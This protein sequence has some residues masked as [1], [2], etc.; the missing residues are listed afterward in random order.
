MRALLTKIVAG[1]MIAGSAL[2]VSA[3]GETTV[4][5]NNTTEVVPAENVATTDEMVSSMDAANGTETNMVDGNM[6]EEGN[7]AETN[8]M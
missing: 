6:M 7:M 1:S 8:A 4:A 3:C 2:L 5:V